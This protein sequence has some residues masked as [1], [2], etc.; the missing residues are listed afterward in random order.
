MSTFQLN[1]FHLCNE[2]RQY[3]TCDLFVLMSENAPDDV[4]VIYEPQS[5]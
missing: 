1:N 2:L 4:K 5:G 3:Y